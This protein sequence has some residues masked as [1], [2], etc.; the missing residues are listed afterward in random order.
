MLNL[1]SYFPITDPTLIFLVVLLI[2][3]LAPIVMGKLRIPHIIGMVLAGVVVGK[4]GFNILVRDDSFE[5]FG[6]VGLYYIM[7][8]AALEMNME[9]V[10]RHP[11]KLIIFGGLTFSVPL[12]MTY[13]IGI[14]VLDYAPAAALL[15][16]CIMASNTLVSYPIISRYGLQGERSVT[17]SVGASMI[18]LTLAL[19]LMAAIVAS[20]T[21]GSGT[22]GFWLWFAMKLLLYC[23]LLIWLIPRLTR[24]F[25][26]RY[27]DAVM[28][29]TFV[30]SVLFLSAALSEY[31]GMEGIFGAFL[32]GLILNRYIPPLSPLMSRI[33]FIGNALFIPYFLIGVG[34]LINVRLVFTGGSV[35][36]AAFWFVLIGTL[37]KAIAA[38]MAGIGFRMPLSNANMM[39]GLTSAHAAGAIAMVMVGM[40]LMMSDGQPMVNNDMLNGIVIM[41]LF[42]CIISSLMTEFAS[43]QIIL[44]NKELPA[45][46]YKVDEK[47]L[48]PV[49]YP[50]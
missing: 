33:E 9:S 10:K 29:F 6:R 31:V 37:G 17:L 34:M 1:G 47:I 30:L 12:V 40:Q 4:D 25:L 39:F 23:S 49:R 50:D 42:T 13:I 3:L 21:P 46:D 27:S 15:L 19:I 48:T 5:L 22:I 2:I 11:T 41:I 7:F 20:H 38:Y 18:A 44:R 28:Q 16:G 24:W 35:L 43:R 45:E 14:S 8:L 32:A 36:W 26:R